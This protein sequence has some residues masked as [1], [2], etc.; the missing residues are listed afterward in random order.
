MPNQAPDTAN[1]PICRCCGQPIL[2]GQPH[3]AGDREGYPW[4]YA[5][6]EMARLTIPCR[7][8]IPPPAV[9]N[10]G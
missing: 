2:K 8:A 10:A 3:W 1:R 6:A 4:H 9:R 7:P 5:C